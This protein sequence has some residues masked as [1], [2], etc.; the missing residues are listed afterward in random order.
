MD[1]VYVGLKDGVIAFAGSTVQIP[2]NCFRR[3]RCAGMDLDYR[4]VLSTDDWLAAW[5]LK[6]DLQKRI[7]QKYDL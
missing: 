1:H 2:R 6:L 5:H 4:V 7:G 3:R